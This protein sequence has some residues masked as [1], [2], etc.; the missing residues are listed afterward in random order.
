MTSKFVSAT[1]TS[2]LNSICFCLFFKILF[3]YSWETHGERQRQRQREKQAPCGELDVGLKPRTPGSQPEPKADAQPWSYPGIPLN[4]TCKIPLS[5]QHLLLMPNEHLI[6][7]GCTPNYW[8][9]FLHTSALVPKFPSSESD[10][11]NPG[12]V[13]DSSLYL[14]FYIEPIYKYYLFYLEKILESDHI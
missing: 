11:K 3:I 12:D 13:L 2:T 8:F 4:S 7:S 5:S 9:Q 10:T 14:I 6:P 1:L